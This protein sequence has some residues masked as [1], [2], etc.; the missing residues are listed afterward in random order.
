[1]QKE[2]FVGDLK[3]KARRDDSSSNRFVLAER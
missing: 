3:Q 1:M 2:L